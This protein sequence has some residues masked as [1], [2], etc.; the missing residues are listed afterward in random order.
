MNRL[1][2]AVV[3]AST[4]LITTASITTAAAWPPGSITLKAACDNK[5]GEIVITVRDK[6]REGADFTLTNDVDDKTRTGT[7]AGRSST[8]VT[9][10]YA[11]EP[12]T[13]SVL[14]VTREN[15]RITASVKVGTFEDCAP[16]KVTPPSTPSPRPSGPGTPAKLPKPTLPTPATPT[17][18]KP[19]TPSPA[20]PA[21]PTPTPTPTPTKSRHVS[22]PR[23]A[24]STTPPARPTAPAAPE[25]AK[26]GAFEGKGVALGIAGALLLGGGVAVA[27]ASR[28]RRQ[29]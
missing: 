22:P 9:V 12:V 5:P 24:P 23:P 26:T 25:L 21:K 2:A 3:L 8:A 17:P 1:R 6:Y 16:P 27:F 20:K 29:D 10:P 15:E 11:G 18:S 13:W 19:A 28:A 7:V 14:A 4:A